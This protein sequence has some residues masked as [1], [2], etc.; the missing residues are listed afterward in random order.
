MMSP[1]HESD[2]RKHWDNIFF[3][4]A[5][6]VKSLCEI[7]TQFNQWETWRK[8]EKAWVEHA[9]FLTL[10][11]MDFYRNL[12]LTIAASIGSIHWSNWVL[13]HGHQLLLIDFS[14]IF[15]I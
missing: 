12:L 11:S 3:P 15:I 6:V 7:N 4:K 5:A 8:E 9:P 1:S 14:A 10:F 2:E 13:Q